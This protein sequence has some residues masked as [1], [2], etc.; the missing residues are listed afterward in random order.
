[1]HEPQDVA[2]LLAG[3]PQ[4]SGK[5]PATGNAG[6]RPKLIALPVIARCA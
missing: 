5:Y 2:A 1:M 3:L 6:L 4:Q